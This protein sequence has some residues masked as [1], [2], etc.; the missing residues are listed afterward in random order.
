MIRCILL[1]FFFV[2][3][4][5]NVLSCDKIVIRNQE[6]FNSLNQQILSALEGDGKQI[7]INIK[8]GTYYYNNDQIK[9]EDKNFP[10]KTII[11]NG[12]GAIILSSGKQYKKGDKFGQVFSDNHAFV[13]EDYYLIPIWSGVKLAKGQIEVLDEK[14]KLCR[15]YYGSINDLKEEDSRHSRIYI[16]HWFQ[17]SRYSIKK[18]ENGY[19]YFT[20]VDLKKNIGEGWNVNDDYNYGKLPNV[21][22]LTCNLKS[23]EDVLRIENGRLIL[24]QGISKVHECTAARFCMI[25]NSSFKRIVFAD[26]TVVGNFWDGKDYL[27]ELEHNNIGSTSL[28]R[29]IFKCMEGDIIGIGKTANVSVFNCDFKDCYRGCVHSDINSP[30]THIYNCSFTNVGLEFENSYI[31]KC[32]GNNYLI[33]NNQFQDYGHCAI[34]VG[35]GGNKDNSQRVAGIIENNTVRYTR[36]YINKNKDGMLMDNGAIYVGTQNDSAIIRN[37]YISGHCGMKDNRGIFLDDGAYNVEIYGNFITG[38]INSYCLDSRRV[39]SVETTGSRGNNVKRSNVNNRIYNNVFD[40]TIRFEA[41]EGENNGCVLGVNYFLVENKQSIMPTSVYSNIDTNGKEVS[42]FVKNRKSEKI[43]VSESDF[44]LIRRIH[45]WR[46]LK[47]D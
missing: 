34:R 2:I 17:K 37:N 44:R 10:E 21:R 35:Y 16:L 29:C 14:T 43:Y 32:Q 22:F 6:D 4:P 25:R 3:I 24:P 36:D 33:A 31:V 26:I 11:I 42:V 1:I 28:N 46:Y 20:A 39:S 30:N 19:V 5:H 8:P 23:E 13:S 38:I 18:I 15:L 12:K 40:G 45:S 9:L 47:K 27:I 41:R 7:V